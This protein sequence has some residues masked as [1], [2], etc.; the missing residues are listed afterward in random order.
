[1]SS[2][3][4][5]TALSRPAPLASSHRRP[6][7]AAPKPGFGLQ[8]LIGPPTCS[9]AGDRCDS[10]FPTAAAIRP[11]VTR[12]LSFVSSAVLMPSRV[13]PP[14]SIAALN[15]YMDDAASTLKF[16]SGCLSND[17]TNAAGARRVA[18]RQV[19][20]DRAR[21]TSSPALRSRPG[22]SPQERLGHVRARE[23]EPLPELQ[24]PELLD[25]RI[26]RRGGGPEPE[27][28]R[29]RV[30]HLRQLAEKSLVVGAKI[31]VSTT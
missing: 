15:A 29:G 9:R 17:C 1:M 19:L 18:L 11:G 20:P 22:T 3:R 27:R 5:V 23:H 26:P 12:R 21:G 25:D 31:V 8:F 10:A 4:R 7:N 24:L 13:G 14:F 16:E 6:P 30:L 28:L 2:R